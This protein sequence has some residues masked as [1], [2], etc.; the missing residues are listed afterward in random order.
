MVLTFYENS[1]LVAL[2][3]LYPEYPWQVWKFHKV[4]RGKNRSNGL[5][6]T[7]LLGCRR[8]RQNFFE[9]CNKR[10]WNCSSR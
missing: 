8:K 5:I 6:S 10:V 2:T 9:N 1:Y 4:P 3:T 7:R